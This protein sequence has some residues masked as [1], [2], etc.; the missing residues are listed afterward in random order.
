[1]IGHDRIHRLYQVSLVLASCTLTVVLMVLF[2]LVAGS[3][4][5]YKPL[6]VK[7]LNVESLLSCP[8]EPV[9]VDFIAY[10]LPQYP[11]DQITI[12]PVWIPFRQEQ[13]FPDAH[14]AS[15][16][17]VREPVSILTSE[18]VENAELIFADSQHFAPE[19]AGRWRL[20]LRYVAEGRIG[21]KERGQTIVI[22]DATELEVASERACS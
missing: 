10:T 4:M 12:S 16:L 13:A 7:D 11:V 2:G 15:P 6:V 17:P 1:V 21:L 22:R 14:A 19:Q 20:E 18:Q 5:P 3:V 8:G 9:A